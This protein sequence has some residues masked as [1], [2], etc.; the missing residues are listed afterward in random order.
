MQSIDAQD[1]NRAR[2]ANSESGHPGR[3]LPTIMGRN[4]A[5]W[6]PNRLEI[7]GRRSSRLLRELTAIGDMAVSWQPPN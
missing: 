4:H 1:V 7:P 6:Q 5:I 3:T 2:P